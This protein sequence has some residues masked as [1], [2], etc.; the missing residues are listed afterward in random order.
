[1]AD[2]QRQNQT[3]QGSVVE[4]SPLETAIRLARQGNRKDA[5]DRFRSIAEADPSHPQA[6][7]WLS[8]L[9]RL[10]GDF[11][12]SICYGKQVVSMRP[13]ESG[14]RSNLGLAYAEAKQFDKA[15]ESF[16]EAI[17]LSPSIPMNYVQL[18]K[19]LQSS[20]REA[21]AL[22]AYK[23]ADQL[24]PGSLET[25]LAISRLSFNQN[26]T[27]EAFAYA[28]SA[29]CADSNS[30]EARLLLAATLID[31]GMAAQAQVHLQT[32]LSS[33]EKNGA[34]FS[35]LGMQMQALG[36]LAEADAAFNK[37]IDIQPEQGISYCALLRNSRV[38]TSSQP[39]LDR[40]ETL[41]ANSDLNPR[42][43]SFL[44]FGLGKAYDDLAQYERAIAHF[45]RANEIAY[46]LKFGSQTWDRTRLSHYVDWT[47]E[48]FTREFVER[49]SLQSNASESPIFVVGMMRSGTT[50]VEQI[51]SS[52]SQVEGAGEQPFWLT[53]AH[54]AVQPGTSVLKLPVLRRLSDAYLEKMRALF[55]KSVRITDKMPGN[56]RVLGVLAA[57]FP[58]AKF[59]HTRRN[60]IDTCLSIYMTP[61]RIANEFANNRENIV[62][63]YRQYQRLAE[64]WE[65]TLPPERLLTVEYEG[66][67]SDPEPV[68]RRLLDFCGLDWE[69]KCLHHEQNE[70][71][72]IT[73]SV[74]QVRQPIYTNSVARWRR[75]E[76]WLGPF[77]SLPQN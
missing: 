3:G 12:Q 61:N 16:R 67:V 24:Q 25:L 73:P 38:L 50:L 55:P 40:M 41:I 17:G 75:Y 36:R 27:E 66:L 1:M 53:H 60:P 18:G 44:H 46:R 69:E 37:S 15:E 57:A 28:N 51:L 68:V 7:T 52:H 22:A 29:L 58:K 70:R 63:A 49:H 32:V 65:R 47:I 45:D 77:A 33:P 72:V 54:E 64:H 11:I 20:G 10:E 5:I 26:L 13:S 14:V 35:L 59:V 39:M 2:D 76:P 42:G 43:L 30:T 23:K 48:T 19:L 4:P 6:L 21:E 74:W 8:V 34:A 56:Y 31:Q 71:S 9:Y 62:F